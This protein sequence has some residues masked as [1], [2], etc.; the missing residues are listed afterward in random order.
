MTIGVV[1]VG[2]LI[3]NPEAD[4]GDDGAGGVGQVVHGV[5]GDRDGAGQGAHQQLEREQQK[6]ANDAHKAR[7][8]ADGGTNLG[9]ACIFRVLDE[10]TKQQIGHDFPPNT[11]L[12]PR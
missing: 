10:Q 11:R 9:A 12:Y 5:G 6:I 2:G 7:H 8:G 3:R 1:R 4:E